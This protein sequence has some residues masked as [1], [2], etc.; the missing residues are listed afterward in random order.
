[1]FRRLQGSGLAGALKLDGSEDPP[2]MAKSSNLR[3]A[4]SPSLSFPVTDIVNAS[5]K[6]RRRT[7]T[8]VDEDI[9]HDLK[10]I[11]GF[12]VD[13]CRVILWKACCEAIEL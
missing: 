2:S 7:L 11:F 12:D 1:M 10:S 8:K 13:P 6:S 5:H 9:V 3:L 4:I